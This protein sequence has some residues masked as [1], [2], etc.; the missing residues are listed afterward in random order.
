MQFRAVLSAAALVLAAALFVLAGG[1]GAA[2]GSGSPKLSKEDRTALAEARANG[3]QQVTLLI[4]AKAGAMNAVASGVS[5]LGG[6]VRQTESSIDYVRATVPTDK[7]E[8]IASLDGVQQAS[9]DILIPLDDPSVDA[10]PTPPG[11]GTPSENSQLPTRDIGA[12]QFVAAHPTYDGRGA[13]IGILDTGIDVLTPELQTA[14]NI[15][16]GTVRKII[17]WKNFN[18]PFSGLDPSW[19]NM[20]TQVSVSGGSFT[21]GGNTYTGVPADGAYR[22]GVFKEADI[23]GSEYTIGCGGDLNRDGVCNETF[24][25]IWNTAS[26]TVWVDSDANKSFAGEKAMKNYDVNYDIG[27]F[28]TDNPSTATRE[29]VPFTIQTDGKDKFINIGVV[30]A[31]HG[32]HVAGIAAGRHFFGGAMNGA[33]PEAQ[34]VSVRV[35]VFG[36][37]CTSAGLIDGMIY[38][39]KQANVDVINMSIGGLPALND[40]NNARAILYNRLID[41]SK[42]Q[43]FISAGNS[44][45]GHNTVGDP[46]VAEKV[47]SVGA[48]VHQ[49]TWFNDYGASS[50]KVEGLFPFSSRGPREDGGLKPNIVAPGAAISTVPAWEP[51]FPLVTPLPPGYDL[52]NGTSMA[53][54]EATGG[55]ALLI[56]AAKQT[57]AQWQPDQLRQAI[58]SGAR[59]LPGEGAYEQGNGIMQVGAA[60]DVLKQNVKTVDITSSAPVN[61]VLSGQLATPNRGE[62][63]YEREGWAAGQTG[64]RTITFTRTSGGSGAITY[65]VSWVGNDGTFSSAGS[66]SLPRG[67]PVNLPV[68]IN[69]AT[70]GIHSA[71][72]RLNDPSTA[73]IDY[74]T[75]NVIVAANQFN[76]AN[77]F[78]VTSSGSADRPDMATFFYNVPPNTPAFKVDVTDVNGRVRV[79]RDSPQGLPID[80]PAFQTGGSQ[81][82]TVSN[83][84]AGVWEVAVEVSRT[85]AA[86]PATFNITGTVLGVDITPSSWTIDPAT[87]GT[88]YNQTFSFTNRFGSFT[89]GA[90]GTPLGSA[91]ANHNTIAAGGAQQIYDVTVPAG[92]T[93]IT[94]QIGNASDSRADLDLFLFDCTTGSCVLRSSSTSASANE[95]VSFNNPAAGLWKI[96]VDPFAVPAGSTTYDE[97]D[98]VSNPAFGSVSV[99]DPPAAHANGSTWSA[100]ASVTAASAPAAGRFL[101]GFVQV[102]S[103]STVLGSAEVDLKNVH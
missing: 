16:G 83:P 79:W 76:V 86:G 21:A 3:E 60:W 67:T 87:V 64:T 17:Q 26:D 48:Y 50:N 63:I 28:G 10:T 31:E 29:T 47:M 82:K 40:G 74:E 101:Q 78:S 22:F 91:G 13:V 57:G 75:M 52:L 24:A 103:G 46:S 89:G 11:P 59:Y 68:T 33:A 25:A 94:S 53:A 12:P 44:G 6:T 14:K 100:P 5:G 71:L 99:T 42:A 38:A 32:T 15:N 8:A 55:A 18:D 41:Q 77:N 34:I 9:L 66:I 95:F 4:A 70:V 90:V 81:S 2:G 61:T 45:P 84:M 19:V 85:S 56:S 73:G 27:I 39:E 51:T 97:L 37:S 62:G 93:R 30:G 54:P 96:L 72:L 98:V 35:C 65:N 23:T 102:K 43:M 36:N 49:D 69:A 7:V 1:A 88:T 20:E 58:N 80:S 92:S